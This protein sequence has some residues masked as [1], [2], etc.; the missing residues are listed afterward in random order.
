VYVNRFLVAL[1][2][3]LEL[4]IEDRAGEELV[5]AGDIAN[6]GESRGSI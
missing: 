6:R 3:T 4:S 5:A 2:T 1:D